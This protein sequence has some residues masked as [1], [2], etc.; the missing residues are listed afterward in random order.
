MGSSTDNL[1][2]PNMEALIL[3]C[4]CSLNLPLNLPRHPS[5]CPPSAPESLNLTSIC[6]GVPQRAPR[7]APASLNL[8]SIFPGVPLSAS[9][10]AP[11]SLTLPQAPLP[12]QSQGRRGQGKIQQGM[13]DKKTSMFGHQTHLHG[14]LQRQSSYEVRLWGPRDWGPN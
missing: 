11:A 12:R 8:S 1:R 14:C 9:A 10:S 13:A 6:P 7:S 2:C 3:V 4:R 5:I